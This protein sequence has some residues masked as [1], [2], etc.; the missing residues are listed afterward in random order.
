MLP[1]E[2]AF[3]GLLLQAN[4]GLDD[5]A[6]IDD[7]L[8]IVDAHG[9]VQLAG[10]VSQLPSRNRDHL[11]R[12]GVTWNAGDVLVLGTPLPRP[13]QAILPLSVNSHDHTFQPPAV[14][15]DLLVETADGLGGWLPTTLIE[16][17][18]RAKRD[19]NKAREM[20]RSRFTRFIDNGV[21]TVL[22]HTTSSI[23]AA[24]VVIEEAAAHG[25]RA[26]VGYVAMNSEVDH[27]QPGLQEADAA[28]VRNT[29]A[30][31][32]EYGPDKVCVID[33]S[34]LVVTP[35][36]RKRLAQL[37][38]EYGALFETHCDESVAERNMHRRIYG[39]D[40]MIRTLYDDGV[41]ALGNRVGLAHAIHSSPQDI[42]LVARA[43]AAGCEV[44][45]RAC[46]NSNG[47][48]RSHWHA[49]RYVRF[50]LAQ[51]RDAGAIITPGT[52][53]GAGRL[54]NIFAESYWER[55]RHPEELPPRQLL[56]M[57]IL[58]GLRSLR[59]DPE[60]ITIKEGHVADFMVV[61]MQGAHAFYDTVQHDRDRQ[62]ARIIEG[63][64]D[65]ALIET[66]YIEGRKL[67]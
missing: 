51:W 3:R 30:I 36:L 14:P 32:D 7:A 55:A 22:Q 27:I 65:P 6:I 13:Q 18:Y 25:L 1:R 61:Q 4:D 24:R 19:L 10:A 31:L 8:V 33:R 46:P 28:I 38:G 20:A 58:N 9:I 37:A 53:Q 54:C 2:R 59:T 23:D 63:A 64:M 5:F 50:P 29:R 45:I 43:I 48:L 42:E 62:L 16:G 26:L 15:G 67:K 34:P 66:V 21:G 41:F 60:R 11:A 49:G 56:A 52:D 47:Q 57:A 44:S 17:E 35:A 12:V 40:S 39:H